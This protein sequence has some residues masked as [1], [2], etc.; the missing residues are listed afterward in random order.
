MLSKL[1]INPIEIGLIL[2][3]VIEERQFF[4][5][6]SNIDSD[7]FRNDII[8]AMSGAFNPA[9]NVSWYTSETM[10]TLLSKA[11]SEAFNV[12]VEAVY[13]MKKLRS[14]SRVLKGA[15][16]PAGHLDSSALDDELAGMLSAAA[17]RLL[18]F[19]MPQV[20]MPQK[21]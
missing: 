11:G 13:P 12:A 10:P 18:L 3:G 8:T 15:L 17:L 21:G 16:W 20:M 5:R 1:G 6:F 9:C 19:L 14:L 7:A 2:S 4:L